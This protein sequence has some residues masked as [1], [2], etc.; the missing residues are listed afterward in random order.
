MVG[1]HLIILH[2]PILRKFLFCAVKNFVRSYF[3]KLFYFNIKQC[4]IKLLKK[5]CASK[6]KSKWVDVIIYL[7]P[8]KTEYT[9][10]E[11][12]VLIFCRSFTN[13]GFLELALFSILADTSTSITMAFQPKYFKVLFYHLRWFHNLQ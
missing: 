10:E 2:W 13:S 8:S 6:S 7:M 9:I 12:D 5:V 11:L 3:M 1:G 4:S